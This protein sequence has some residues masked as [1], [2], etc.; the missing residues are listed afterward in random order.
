MDKEMNGNDSIQWDRVTLHWLDALMDLD[1]H[2]P[3]VQPVVVCMARWIRLSLPRVISLADH[4]DGGLG[5]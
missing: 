4:F 1:P 3:L 2:M 5:V